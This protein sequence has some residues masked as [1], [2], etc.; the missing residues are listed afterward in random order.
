[1]KKTEKYQDQQGCRATGLF[2]GCWWSIN[3]S[4]LEQCLAGYTELNICVP[5]D[6]ETPLL[7]KCTKEMRP[8]VHQKI[9]TR[10]FITA[11]LKIAPN[12]KLRNVHQ[13]ENGIQLLDKIQDAPLNVNFRKATIIFVVQA[14]PIQQYHLKWATAVYNRVILTDVR[15]SRRSQTQNYTNWVVPCVWSSKNRQSSSTL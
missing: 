5:D 2:T 14:G 12:W 10:I 9:C 8:Y 4:H 1:M 6:P 11:L 3:W 7:G 15:K 13:Q